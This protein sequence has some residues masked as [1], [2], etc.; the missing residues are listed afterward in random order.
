[1]PSTRSTPSL[2]SRHWPI[3][4][5][6]LGVAPGPF[7]TTLVRF[8]RSKG[9][10]QGEAIVQA[11]MEHWCAAGAD[12]FSEIFDADPD[13]APRGA[14]AQAWSVAELLRAYVEDLGPQAEGTYLAEG[15]EA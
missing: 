4:R 15:S 11:V 8:K 12:T 14:I 13:F 6:R 3:T 7:V 9:R 2:L 5:H 1:M 10:A